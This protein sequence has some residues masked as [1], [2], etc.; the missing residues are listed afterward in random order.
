MGSKHSKYGTHFSGQFVQTN[1]YKTKG[2]KWIQSDKDPWKNIRYNS[3]ISMLPIELILL[4]FITQKD[5]LYAINMLRSF[6]SYLGCCLNCY[7][8]VSVGC[9][10]PSFRYC[11]C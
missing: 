1:D 9:F 7:S 6:D 11:C 10:H 2:A 4:V 5:S 3:L 8:M